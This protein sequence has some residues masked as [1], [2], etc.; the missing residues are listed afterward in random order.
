SFGNLLVL[1]LYQQYLQQGQA[2]VPKY[3]GLLSA[4]GSKRPEAIL[5]DVG[6]NIR[7]EE[8]WQSGFDTITGMV[9]ELERTA[10]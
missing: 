2:F 8:F 7:S 9:E 1:A 4:G 6:I 5:A 3:L 10:T